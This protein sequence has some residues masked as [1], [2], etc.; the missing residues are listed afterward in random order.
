MG[1]RV[2]TLTVE[3]RHLPGP[4][5]GAG[6]ARPGFD[7]GRTGTWARPREVAPACSPCRRRVGWVRGAQRNATHRS[8]SAPHLGFPLPGPALT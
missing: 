3:T 2:G 8:A 5:G 4:A 1:W 7:R 6:P